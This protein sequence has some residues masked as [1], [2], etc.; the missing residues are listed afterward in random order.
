MMV[1]AT[2]QSWRD[3]S[4][5]CMSVPGMLDQRPLAIQ[6]VISVC[7]AFSV[8]L[9]VEYAVLSAFSEAFNN[10]VLHSYRDTDGD[11]DVELEIANSRLTVELRDGG[12]GFDPQAVPEPELSA[13]PERG[14]G[15]FIILRAMDDVRW[16][17]RNGQNVLVMSKQL[18]RPL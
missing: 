12:I 4:R 7:R 15:L 6:F 8:P 11:V 9:D 2:T 3:T 16:M 14:L 13:L 17:Q 10:I 18:P 5:F 1:R